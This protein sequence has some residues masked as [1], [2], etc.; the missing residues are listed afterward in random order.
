MDYFKSKYTTL[1]DNFTLDRRMAKGEPLEVIFDDTDYYSKCYSEDE[2]RPITVR[3]GRKYNYVAN[4]FL[5]FDN[6]FVLADDFQEGDE[7]SYAYRRYDSNGMREGGVL[8]RRN[9]TYVTRE[10][11]LDIKFGNHN[12]HGK[13]AIVKQYDGLFN[14]IDVTTGAK[15]DN[16]G[17]D[18]DC[19]AVNNINYDFGIF[20]AAK[21]NIKNLHDLGWWADAYIKEIATSKHLKVN[22]CSFDGG[23]ISPNLWFDYTDGFQMVYKRGYLKVANF[24]VVYLNNKVNFISTK[25]HLL[26]DIW[27]D[28]ASVYGAEDGIAGI[29]KGLSVKN[30]PDYCN[31]NYDYNPAKYDLFYIDKYGR[32]SEIK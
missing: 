1:P 28:V 7:Y 31:D 2:G 5:L 16:V 3:I 30:L 22:F 6:W 12:G 17:L 29:L 23:I 10:E 14:V 26:S 20:I 13:Y 24:A 4:N 15:L 8:I 18:V 21:G 27:F 32:I 11:F 19:I 9:G 25:G